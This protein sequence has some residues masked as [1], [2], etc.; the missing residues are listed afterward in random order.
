MKA[1]FIVPDG[2]LP[3]QKPEVFGGEWHAI[4]LD[5]HGTAGAGFHV[6]VTPDANYGTPPSWQ[7]MPH[8]LDAKTTIASHGKGHDK[9][10]SDTPVKSEHTAFEAAQALAA[11]HPLFMP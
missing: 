4:H 8:L 1:Y 3:R 9:L 10:L 7:P 2:E 6:L 11:I 5:S